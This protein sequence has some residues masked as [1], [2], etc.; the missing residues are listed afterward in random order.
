[1]NL[2]FSEVADFWG[3]NS[4][5][6]PDLCNFA[7]ARPRNSDTVPELSEIEIRKPLCDP[8]MASQLSYGPGTWQ[9]C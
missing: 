4:V 6:A 7:Q 3:R 8:H 9:N 5:M 1:M 2:S